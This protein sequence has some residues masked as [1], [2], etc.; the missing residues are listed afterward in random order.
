VSRQQREHAREADMHAQE[1]AYLHAELEAAR[2][3][4]GTPSVRSPVV[5]ARRSSERSAFCMRL[6]ITVAW[7]PR[8]F[9]AARQHTGKRW[10]SSFPCRLSHCLFVPVLV[11][12]HVLGA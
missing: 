5:S 3:V 11:F 10:L 4:R 1:L 12:F 8:G 6:P 9:F 2:R 7:D